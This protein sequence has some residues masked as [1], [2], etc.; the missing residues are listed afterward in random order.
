MA[1][2][3]ILQE[4]IFTNFL[5]PFVLLFFLI[6]AI[7]EKTKVLGENKQIDAFVS[8]VISLIFVGAVFPK[9]FVGN[10]MLFLSLA[11][12]VVFVFLIIFSFATGANTIS[13]GKNT[14]WIVGIVLLVIIIIAIIWAAGLQDQTVNFIK[15]LG[16]FDN[17][18]SNVLFILVIAGV[19]AIVLATGKKSS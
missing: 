10:L 18:W 8:L 1:V 6:F 15:D 11:L 9:I 5:F 12:V 14:K 4:P 16:Q 3:T 13:P 7:L 19:V 2:E 17:F